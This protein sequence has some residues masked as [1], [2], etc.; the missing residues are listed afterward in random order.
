MV[1]WRGFR[2]LILV[3]YLLGALALVA[4][5]GY[6]FSIIRVPLPVVESWQESQVMLSIPPSKGLDEF[7]ATPLLVDTPGG[8][9]NQA[10]FHLGRDDVMDGPEQ[11]VMVGMANCS[12]ISSD[13]DQGILVTREVV[14]VG[15]RYKPAGTFYMS[16]DHRGWQRQRT[17][18]DLSGS[19]VPL[20]GFAVVDY[21]TQG[22]GSI[23]MQWTELFT[24]W[25]CDIYSST[26]DN[27][28]LYEVFDRVEYTFTYATAEVR[29]VVRAGSCATIMDESGSIQLLSRRDADVPFETEYPDGSL[30]LYR[31][32]V[33]SVIYNLGSTPVEGISIFA[34]TVMVGWA[35]GA[36]NISSAPALGHA[37]GQ[38]FGVETLTSIRPSNMLSYPYF[39]GV[40]DSASTGCYTAAADVLIVMGT[41]MYLIMIMRIVAGPPRL[42]SWIGQHIYLHGRASPSGHMEDEEMTLAAGYDPAP[43]DRLFVQLQPDKDAFV[44]QPESDQRLQWLHGRPQRQ[45]QGHVVGIQGS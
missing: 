31:N 7:G 44:G 9:D 22:P 32:W 13:L 23:A 27:S 29:R 19:W 14:M 18:P 38:P 26:C 8:L 39:T 45:G 37:R 11:I 6:K 42:T 40:R 2:L 43:V 20:L 25:N 5:I 36:V 12:S 34:R 33:D 30:P 4:T 1:G 10:F 21:Y 16:E 17:V 3:S 35:N 15:E 41:C 28:T 24:G